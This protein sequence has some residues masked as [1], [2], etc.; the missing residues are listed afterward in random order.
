MVFIIDNNLLNKVKCRVKKDHISKY[1][2]P[3][4]NARKL[5]SNCAKAV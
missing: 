4:A 5:L 3:Y 1:F 2:V